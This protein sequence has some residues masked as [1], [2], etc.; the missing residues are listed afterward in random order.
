MQNADGVRWAKVRAF[1]SLGTA[2][3][4]ATLP[5]PPAPWPLVTRLD[6]ASD[7]MLS[8]YHRDTTSGPLQLTIAAVPPG[9]CDG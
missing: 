8:L 6:C 1:G 3:D 4:P 2:D 5:L 9:E 7:R